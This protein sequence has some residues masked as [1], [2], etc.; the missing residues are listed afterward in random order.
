[1]SAIECKLA[2]WIEVAISS[3]NWGRNEVQLARKKPQHMQI[4]MWKDEINQVKTTALTMNW[5]HQFMQVELLGGDWNGFT[6]HH[7]HKSS[8][9]HLYQL[10]RPPAEHQVKLGN[11]DETTCLRRW[12]SISA[13]RLN[14]SLSS[15]RQSRWLHW[16]RS[17]WPLIW[18]IALQHR[19]KRSVRL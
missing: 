19:S 11:N 3:M 13:D 16:I 9:C 12:S 4:V 5:M 1:M 15:H 10:I 8:S 14:S 6:E 2:L 18:P 7:D 17:S